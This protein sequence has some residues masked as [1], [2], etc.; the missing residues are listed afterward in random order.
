[1]GIEFGGISALSHILTGDKESPC[2]GG[3][4]LFFMLRSKEDCDYDI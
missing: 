3:Y 2:D 1:M 4:Y